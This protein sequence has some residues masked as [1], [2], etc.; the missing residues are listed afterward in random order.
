MLGKQ[1][2]IDSAVALVNPAA[3][4]VNTA[5]N[6]TG[7]L[8]LV[9]EFNSSLRWFDECVYTHTQ[10][11]FGFITMNFLGLSAEQ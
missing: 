1:T 9:I 11:H 6:Q 5:D 2:C 3:Q 4:K 10:T 8:A 7:W